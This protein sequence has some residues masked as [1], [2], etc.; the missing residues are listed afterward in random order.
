V[1]AVRR[2]H[3]APAWLLAAVLASSA[4]A[5]ARTPLA[6]PGPQNG[7]VQSSGSWQISGICSVAQITLSGT[8][9]VLVTGPRLLVSGPINMTGAASLAIQTTDFVLAQTVAAQFP[10]VAHD[11]SL[12]VFQG[13]NVVTNAAVATNCTAFLQAY[14]DAQVRFTN[15]SLETR[16]SWLLAYLNDRSRLRVESSTFA[17]TEIYPRDQA[18]L[19]I[20]GAMTSVRTV[21]LIPPHATAVVEGLPAA[22]PFSYRFG[23]GEPTSS[24]IG[25]LVDVQDSQTRVGVSVGPFS[26]VTLRN[27]VRPVTVSYL[28][29]SDAQPNWLAGLRSGMAVT[30]T[31]EHQG[32]HLALE[33]TQL[34]DVGWQVY[35][36]R[37]GGAAAPFVALDDAWVNE[38]GALA[39][40]RLEARD[41]IFQYAFLAAFSPGSHV[42]VEDS[43]INSQNVRANDGGVLEIF[44]SQIWGSRLDANGTGR[45]RLTNV[46]LLD[47]VCHAACLP[48]CLEISGGDECNSYNPALSVAFDARDSSA[49]LG[50]RLAPIEAPV[51]AGTQLAL[52]GD[53]YVASPVA[54]LGAFAWELS[55]RSQTEPTVVVA[56]GGGASLRDTVLGT[57]DTGALAP[58]DWTSHL[59]LGAPG[60]PPLVAERFVRIITP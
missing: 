60:E 39:D 29:M 8:A 50:A 51:A 54:A 59:E 18:T 47:N 21:L 34:F 20:A 44:E 6:C 11:A 49:I 3:F 4:A 56:S 24:G 38:I 32:R 9:D 41:S 55:M 37:L 15:D 23:R 42:R 57:V 16:Y 27:D 30:Q 19:E 53:V 22:N 36:E 40:S 58:G 1:K 26:D 5:Q 12:L 14:D 31:L 35:L 7:L 52:A 2:T 43:V 46:E 10:I 33:Q 25:Y 45:L 28:F 17:P 13:T 48:A